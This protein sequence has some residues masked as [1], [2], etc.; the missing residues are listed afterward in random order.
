[1]LNEDKVILPEVIVYAGPNGS[2]KKVCKSYGLVL[3]VRRYCIMEGC[4]S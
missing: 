1:M 4:D 3:Y 2:G